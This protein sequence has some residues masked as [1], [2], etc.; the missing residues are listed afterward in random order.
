L[1]DIT[2]TIRGGEPQSQYSVRFLQGMVNRMLTSYHKYGHVKDAIEAGVDPIASLQQRLHKYWET[3]NTEYLMD[4]ANYAMME[5]MHPSHD[6]A[7][8]DAESSSPGRTLRSGRITDKH[9][10]DL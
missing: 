10:E 6:A 4:A 2:H 1:T 5:Y 8:F 7:Y 9:A 3:G